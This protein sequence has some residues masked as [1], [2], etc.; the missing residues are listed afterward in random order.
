MDIFGFRSLVNGTIDRTTSDLDDDKLKV[1]GDSL[2]LIKRGFKDSL[3]DIQKP[4]DFRI[5]DFSDSI[6][7]SFPSSIENLSFVFKTLKS[8]PIELIEVGIL[9]RGRIVQGKILHTL[10]MILGPAM[11]N[12]YD[13]ESKSALYSRITT[14]TYRNKF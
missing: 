12:A 9:L 1:L 14:Q 13:S 11:I 10:D 6:A 7:V 2:M 5:T 8:I 3:E 4:F